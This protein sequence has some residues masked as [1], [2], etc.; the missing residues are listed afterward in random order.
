MPC[1]YYTAAE[2][3]NM[4]KQELSDTRK[5]LQKAV[6]EL[7]KAT[8]LLCRI[9]KYIDSRETLEHHGQIKGLVKWWEKHQERDRKREL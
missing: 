2:E 7:N 3:A 8:K 9:C 4:A 5:D 6:K 1:T